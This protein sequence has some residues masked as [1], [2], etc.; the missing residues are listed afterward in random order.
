[1]EKNYTDIFDVM[2]SKYKSMSKGYKRLTEFI[3]KNLDQAA[4]MTAKELG[5]AAQVSESTTVRYAVF[6]GYDGFPEFSQ[7]LSQVVRNELN[8]ISKLKVA[9][10]SSSYSEIINGIMKSDI[11]KISETIKLADNLSFEAATEIISDARNIYVIGIRQDAPLAGFLAFYLNII[12]GNTRLIQTTSINEI[13]EQLLGITEEDLLIGISFPRYSKRTLKALEFANSRNAR[14]ITFTDSVNSPVNLYTPISLF[15][16]SDSVSVV[17]SLVAP[18]SLMNA[19]IVA[20]CVKDQDRVNKNL[21]LIG[22]LWYDYT[23]DGNDEIDVA[24]DEKLK[25]L[26]AKE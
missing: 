7:A 12:Y 22:N 4:F 6:L 21:Q 24:D 1:M 23:A 19:L 14:V 2:D 10:G 25:A 3:K 26:S 18:L 20:L 13:Y 11:D 9:Y 5:S 15:A 8:G 17:D 16:R